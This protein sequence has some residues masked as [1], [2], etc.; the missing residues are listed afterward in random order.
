MELVLIYTR[1]AFYLCALS[2]QSV[3]A[4]MLHISWRRKLAG[5]G[6]NTFTVDIQNQ[7]WLCHLQRKSSQTYFQMFQ[8]CLSLN[9]VLKD[10]Q[11]RMPV[12]RRYQLYV[13]TKYFAT[14]ATLGYQNTWIC[15]HFIYQKQQLCNKKLD[16]GKTLA[17]NTKGISKAPLSK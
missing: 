2:K 13:Y 15:E 5:M 11:R 6:V 4:L 16:T 12:L 7:L 9:N 3:C 1:A 14:S 10:Q 8:S 17:A